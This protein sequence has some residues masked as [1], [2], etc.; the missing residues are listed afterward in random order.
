M[1]NLQYT[2]CRVPGNTSQ[3]KPTIFSIYGVGN[4]RLFLEIT[5]QNV[6]SLP[7]KC[8]GKGFLLF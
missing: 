1:Y 6:S 2:I 8:Q 7:Q 5:K 3:R 4:L